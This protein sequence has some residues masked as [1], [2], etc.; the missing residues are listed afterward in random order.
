MVPLGKFGDGANYIILFS[1]GAIAGP[2]LALTS[3]TLGLLHNLGQTSTLGL[4]H[5]LG[6]TSV[7]F[8]L[9]SIPCM[10]TV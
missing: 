10:S 2:R 3:G 6:Q 5:N 1:L 8:S 4:L 7:L 9:G